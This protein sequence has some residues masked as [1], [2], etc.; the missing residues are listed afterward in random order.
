MLLQVGFLVFQDWGRCNS[1]ES[2][3]HVS[4]SMGTADWMNLLLPIIC[5]SII[6]SAT[7][8]DLIIHSTS[9]K[10]TKSRKRLFYL[11]FLGFM[12]FLHYR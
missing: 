9:Y 12:V 7:V 4:L 11:S 5:C 1:V 3:S 10:R 8:K 6:I 2:T